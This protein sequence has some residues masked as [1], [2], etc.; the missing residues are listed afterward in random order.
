M[1]RELAKNWSEEF[2]QAIESA[3]LTEDLYHCLTCGKCVG[4]CPVAAI[5]PSYNPR[6]I[7]REVLLGNFSR[8]VNSEEIWRC[9]WCATCAS[10]CPSEIKFPMLMLMLR[11]YA[12]Q[13]G[14]GRKYAVVFKRF[15]DKAKEDGVTFLPYSAK[16]L[17]KI[18]AL[19]V[20]LGLKPLREVSAAAKKEYAVLYE[21]SGTSEWL[22]E[23]EAAAE[24][25]LALTFAPGRI[26]CP[27]DADRRPG[28]AHGEG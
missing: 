28:R 10:T 21:L 5:T 18:T 4:S 24:G 2:R 7:I 3:G 20:S 25:P 27:E 15:V 14:S 16:R 9:F 26:R 17:E 23:L 1:K 12:L 11:Y 22:N 13:H 6:Q 8:L 19:R